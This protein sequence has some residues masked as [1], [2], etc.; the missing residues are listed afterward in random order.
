MSSQQT[1]PANGAEAKALTTG[2]AGTVARKEFG[3]EQMAVQAETAAAALAAQAKAMVE[4]RF[5]MAMR[6][7][8]DMDDVRV[9]LLKACE[10]PGFAG[11]TDPKEKIFGAAWYRKPVGDGVEGFT[12][13][14]AEEAI[15]A[16]GNIDCQTTVTWD[17][18]QKR[19]LTV[20][21]ID[22]ENNNGFPSS[23][24]VEKTVERK[25]LK[26]GQ[27]ALL[28]RINSY[29]EP[30]YI[31]EATDDEV[32]SK[33]NNL[34]SKTIRNEVLRVL[35]G[36]IQA[37]CRDRILEIRRGAIAKDPDKAR[38]SIGDAF[39]ALNVL[40]S[41]LKEYLGH[42]LG[43]ASPAEIDE[44]RDVYAAIHAGEHT[45]AEVLA[46]KTGEAPKEVPAPQRPAA[47]TLKEKLKAEASTKAPAPAATE[48]AAQACQHPTVPAS[49]LAGVPK[50]KSVVCEMCAAELPGTLELPP[51]ERE[52]GDDA[53][54][55]P[56]A[57]KPRQTKLTE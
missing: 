53:D 52:P 51:M 24:V 27:Q 16:L 14:F 38:R 6:R 22:L 11:S 3:G 26:R 10:R 19:I 31:V 8:R 25:Q 23:V 37:A 17:D 2:Q 47:D 40:P 48:P 20:N 56:K 9:K 15:R 12:I 34:V 44:L 42:D 7:P 33:Q 49:R 55:A 50:G 28:T 57:G 45:W 13:R 46:A 35:P 41:M 1:A 5:I 54:D 30:V 36:D 39:A 18:P 21:V 43:T 32:F 29:G 4:A